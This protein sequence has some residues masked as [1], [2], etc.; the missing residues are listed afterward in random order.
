VSLQKA[1]STGANFTDATAAKKLLS[2]L[3]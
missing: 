3:N 2:T 1:I